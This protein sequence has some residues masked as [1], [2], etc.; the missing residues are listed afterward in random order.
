MNKL[1]MIAGAMVAVTAPAYAVTLYSS[2]FDTGASASD[3][4]VVS[5]NSAADTVIFGD[6]YGARGVAEAPSTPSGAAAT[7]GLYMQTNK[8]AT[9]VINGINAYL[10]AGGVH[11]FTGDITVSF[12]MWMNVP[13][14]LTN[15]TEQALFGIN[16][17]GVGTNT[18]TGSTQTGADGVWYHMANEGGYG[19]TSTTPNSRDFVGY[20]NNT[21][22]TGA[23]FDNGEEPFLSLFPSGPLAGAP[24]NSWVR[25][26]IEEIAG[27][28]ELRF[29]GT[30]ITNFVNTSAA[31]GF[32]FLGYQDPF[33]SSLGA[34]SLFVVYDNLTVTAVPEPASMIALGAGLLA[35]ARRRRKA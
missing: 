19:N 26:E 31:D 35:L 9:G 2:T 15:T 1:M 24:G 13:S 29:N 23:R 11:T 32:V 16:T 17:D 18:R 8:G 21:V 5:V 14:T 10:T 30:T 12:D 25:V 3:F 6:N 27:N 7:S 34:T 28:V 4:N 33:S 20:V 22:P